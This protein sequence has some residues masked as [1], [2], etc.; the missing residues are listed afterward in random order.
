MGDPFV[1]VIAGSARGHT[2]HAPPSGTQTRPT[3]DKVREALFNV[4]G[5]IDAYVVLDLFAGTGALGI[6]ALSRGARS[7][8]FVEMS[9]K[10]C[11]VLR[12]NVNA[13]GF[14]DRSKILVRDVR[15][16]VDQDATSMGAPFDLVLMDPPYAHGLEQFALEALVKKKGWLS[17]GASVVVE[18]STRDKFV[19][20]ETVRSAF[21]EEPYE[22][23]YGD[24]TLVFWF[25]YRSTG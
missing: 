9:E 8:V 24:T 3:T 6:E 13:C 20:S 25:G 10:V 1:R 17:E 11:S 21:R 14:R 22:K 7:C 18:R 15:R 12:R 5:P 2:L 16:I 19:W 4:L 23:T